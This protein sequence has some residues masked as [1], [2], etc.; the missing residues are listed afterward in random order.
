MLELFHV[1]H[2]KQNEMKKENQSLK[3]YFLGTLLFLCAMCILL[4]TTS[5]NVYHDTE[6]NGKAT[7]VT[8]DTTIIKHTN[9]IKYPKK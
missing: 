6:V 5:C 3:Y 4:C 7:I 8:T 1:E 2:L 9:F